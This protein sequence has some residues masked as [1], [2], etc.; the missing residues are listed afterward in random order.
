MKILTI[1]Y[2]L[3]EGGI[4]MEKLDIKEVETA[5]DKYGDIV[6]SKKDENT[7]I[8][9]NME[10]YKMKEDIMNKLKKSEEE[11]ERG[12]GISADIFFKELR[13]KYDY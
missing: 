11:I 8:I 13:Q 9:M 7:I 4:I 6:L 1:S 12:E 3:L 10:E 2:I 5:L